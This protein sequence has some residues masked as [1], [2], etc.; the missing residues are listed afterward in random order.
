MS[1]FF[2]NKCL[3]KNKYNLCIFLLMGRKSKYI[4]DLTFAEQSS[5]KAGYTYG[6]SPLYRRKCH[7]ILLSYQG[8][9]SQDLSSFF[10]VSRQSILTWFRLWE[11]EGLSGLALKTGRGRKPKLDSS[12]STQVEIVKTF[13]ENEPQNLGKVRS[14]IQE[15]LGIELS[16]KTLIRF[17]KSLNIS[18]SDLRNV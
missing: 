17:L 9:S 14:Q 15:K 7:C 10:N 13:V 12:N 18:G 5:L 6:K 1:C 16:K 3:D 4:K 8:K 2:C 11:K